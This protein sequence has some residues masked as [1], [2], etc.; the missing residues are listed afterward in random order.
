MSETTSFWT[1]GNKGQVLFASRLDDNLQSLLVGEVEKVLESSALGPSG[2]ASRYRPE[3][4]F[5]VMLLYY[6]STYGRNRPTPGMETME[7]GLISSS[8]RSR[9]GIMAPA[10]I[11]LLV[12]SFRRLEMTALTENWEALDEQHDTN[13]AIPTKWKNKCVRYLKVIR[14][15]FHIIG[16]VNT[17]TFLWKGVFVSMF[18]RI[19]GYQIGTF[20]SSNSNHSHPVYSNAQQ[21]LKSRKIGWLALVQLA[22][23]IVYVTSS[24]AAHSTGSIGMGGLSGEISWGYLSARAHGLLTRSYRSSIG[25]F[26]HIWMFLRGQSS[27]SESLSQGIESDNTS[28]EHVHDLST[29]ERNR[30]TATNQ[31]HQCCLCNNRVENAYKAKCEHIFCYLCWYT[32]HEQNIEWKRQHALNPHENGSLVPVLCPTCDSLL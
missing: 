8:S 25:A 2:V 21:M 31:A 6:L 24:A 12:Y 13:S 1:L 23:T 19:L 32:V 3:I 22:A 26:K 18:H 10:A 17:L 4:E 11:L 7:L 16:V 20:S 29:Q 9:G 28:M 14:S 30:R 5:A 15:L 27:T